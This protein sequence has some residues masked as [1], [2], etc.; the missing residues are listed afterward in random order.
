MTRRTH[1]VR[2]PQSEKLTSPPFPSPTELLTVR[3]M[4]DVEILNVVLGF[5]HHTQSAA[6]I[7][8]FGDNADLFLS[9]Y[10][11]SWQLTTNQSRRAKSA[12]VKRTAMFLCRG[13]CPPEVQL[14]TKW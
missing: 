10:L 1:Y 13:N 11:K 12:A 2:P 3:L 14:E 5:G 9:G 7:H 6:Q 8:H 4:E